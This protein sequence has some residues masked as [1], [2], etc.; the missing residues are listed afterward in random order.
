M[1]ASGTTPDTPIEI[2]DD[3]FDEV[4]SEN[5]LVLVDFW[6]EWCQPCHMVAPTIEALA[7]ENEKLLC[8]KVNVDTSPKTAMKFQI[9]SIPTIMLFQ[10]G[11]PV[12]TLIG[13]APKEH[14][15]KVLEKYL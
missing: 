9:A 3:N 5:P 13:A 4:I 8:G 2:T 11:K 1:S 7:R 15:D 6:A 10:D 14:F 12:E